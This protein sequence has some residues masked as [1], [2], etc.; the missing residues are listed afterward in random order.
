MD[1]KN[2]LQKSPLDIP[3][4]LWSRPPNSMEFTDD[5]GVYHDIYLPVGTAHAAL[6]HLQNK[7][8]DELAKFEPFDSEKWNASTPEQQG[9]K[10]INRGGS[11]EQG[12]EPH[13]VQQQNAQEEK[14]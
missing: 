12:A 10:P 14:K 11:K 8:W 13:T 9:F 1:D 2:K 7:R 5:N 4:P 3:L 6:D